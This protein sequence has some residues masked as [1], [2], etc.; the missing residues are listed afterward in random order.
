MR[1]IAQAAS[2]AG[3]VDVVEVEAGI[4][5]S[6]VAVWRQASLTIRAVGGRVRLIADGA[7]AEE[8]AIWVIRNGEFT[9]EGFEF[10]GARVPDGNG[11]GIRFERGRLT[12]RDSRDGDGNASYEL[13]FPD[14]GIARVQA[15]LIEQSAHSSNPV[16]VSIGAEGYRWPVNE[17][18]MSD[19]TVVNRRDG[20]AVFVRAAL[21]PMR[22]TLTGNTW[23]GRGRLEL[24][25]EYRESGNRRVGLADNARR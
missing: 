11:A 21:G 4:Y 13:E 5:P 22:A 9:I 23:V 20:A 10:A 16:I 15:N 8:K 6:D 14:G 19:N 18:D 17:L 3:D 12:V 1:T 24:P 7:N 2:I 25:I